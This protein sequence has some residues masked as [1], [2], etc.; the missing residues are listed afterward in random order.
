MVVLVGATSLY[1]SA[2][3]INPI[4]SIQSLSDLINTSSCGNGI[5]EYGES[6]DDGNLNDSDACGNNCQIRKEC[7]KEHL[8]AAPLGCRYEFNR[9]SDGC[10]ESYLLCNIQCGD[11]KTNQATEE[12]DDGNT[13]DTDFCSNSCKKA[14]CGDGMVQQ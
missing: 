6:C 11:G 2:Q 10:Q 3:G 8:A 5:K 13:V 4:F 1:L 9:N 12:C 14:S 7:Q